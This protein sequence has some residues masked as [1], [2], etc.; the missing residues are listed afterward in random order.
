MTRIDLPV[1]RAD[2]ERAMTTVLSAG[3]HHSENPVYLEMLRDAHHLPHFVDGT[4]QGKRLELHLIP[5][6]ANQPFPFG[7]AMIGRDERR[8]P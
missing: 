5:M 6:P 2:V 1:H 8:S 7:E 3:W 4:L